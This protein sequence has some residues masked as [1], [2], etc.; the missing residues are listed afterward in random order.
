MF[1]KYCSKVKSSLF[2][3]LAL[4]KAF[5]D[6][7]AAFL[8]ARYI[9]LAQTKNYHELLALTLLAVG[10]FALFTLLGLGYRKIRA[11][12]LKDVNVRFKNDLVAYLLETDNALKLDI[13]YLT[14]DLKQLETARIE[15]Q[16]NIV[17]YSFQFLTSFIAGLVANLLLTFVYALTSL[18]PAAVQ[19]LFSKKVETSSVAWQK[20][21]SAYTAKIEELLKN[22]SLIKLYDIRKLFSTKMEKPILNLE[23]AL[24]K[25]KLNIGYT[26]EALVGTSFITMIVVPFLLGIYLI[27][28]GHI[29]VG[30]FLMIAQLSNNFTSPLLSILKTFNTLKTTNTIYQKYLTAKK[31][32][33]TLDL[34]SAT[35]FASLDLNQVSYKELYHE[36]D[37]SVSKHEKLL[38]TAPS[39]FGKTTLFKI[40]LG[41][42]TPDTGT[43]ELNGAPVDRAS[44]HTYF[45]HVAQEP[46]IFADTLRFNLC[47]GKDVSKEKLAQV[48][49]LTGL[50]ELVA[51][52]GLDSS[53]KA[54]GSDLSG[55]QKQRIELARALLQERPVLLVDEGT[56]A[57]DPKLSELIHQKAIAT[58]DG[59]VIEIA[60][61]LSPKE[62]TLFT[63]TLAL[64]E[65]N[66]A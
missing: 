29:T 43:Y 34:P 54:D 8:V 37:L 7:F 63:K 23:E 51:Q 55:G 58:F 31:T 27:M 47:L 14:N 42:L 38:W 62:Q 13:S 50:T 53:L 2:L 44:V 15:G 65:L 60:H 6:V 5:E 4:V 64:N 39:G 21:N 59:T 30:V 24:R 20:S 33:R 45:A 57:L 35:D 18:V 19:R 26:T 3:V 52:R 25:M 36:L 16:L 28:S 22:L 66:K 12:L 46:R 49:D 32:K 61:K 17:F 10:G 1:Y 41:E 56:S 9:N 40:L 48:L 11:S